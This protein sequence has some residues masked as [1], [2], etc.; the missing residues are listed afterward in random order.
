MTYSHEYYLK[1]K[2]KI[3]ENTKKWQEKN[4]ERYKQ[5]RR[6]YHKKYFK[7]YYQ[8]HKHKWKRYFYIHKTSFYY[9]KLIIQLLGGKC[10]KC[11]FSDWRA[12]QIDHI[13][14]D[15]NTER[16]KQKSPSCIYKM[17]FESINLKENKYQLLCA[18]CNWIKRY[19][20]NEHNK[21]R[22]YNSEDTA[23]Y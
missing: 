17:I 1:H 6:E 18:N 5:Y 3:I 7:R 9:R 19:E 12:L 15:G 23:I 20:K 21:L 13:N 11:G 22:K 16:K 14:G 10:V 8:T 2:P 4:I